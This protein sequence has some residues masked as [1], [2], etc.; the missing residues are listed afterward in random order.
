MAED[1]HPVQRDLQRKAHEVQRH[2]D[3]RPRHGGRVAREV[4]ERESGGSAPRRNVQIRPDLRRNGWTRIAQAQKRLGIADCTM[5]IARHQAD[6]QTE[7]DLRADP[8][9]G[10]V[11]GAVPPGHDRVDHRLGHHGQLRDQ[12]GPGRIRKSCQPGSGSRAIVVSDGSRRTRRFTPA[13]L[14]AGSRISGR[15]LQD[16]ARTRRRRYGTAFASIVKPY[17]GGPIGRKV[18]PKS[19]A[20]RRNSSRISCG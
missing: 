11:F 12:V 4:A 19:Y 18:T 8:D 17:A 14:I 7:A 1:E 15:V 5:G 9:G 13:R 16:A 6:E 20:T 10:E 2:H 3:A